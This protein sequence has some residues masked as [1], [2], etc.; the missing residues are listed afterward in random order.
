VLRDHQPFDLH[1]AKSH[2]AL[3]EDLDSVA[4]RLR[5]FAAFNK[6]KRAGQGGMEPGRSNV[7]RLHSVARSASN[8][9]QEFY[10]K[11][12]RRWLVFP[13]SSE[14]MTRGTYTRAFVIKF[15]DQTNLQSNEVEGSVEH[16]S[17]GSKLHFHSLPQ[18]IAF[19]DRVLKESTVSLPSRLR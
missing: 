4:V 10:L 9:R 2:R 16:V 18:L 14:P 13:N 11:Q 17:S 12:N 6:R 1:H 7:Q 8:I 3:V 5:G 15:A 19:M